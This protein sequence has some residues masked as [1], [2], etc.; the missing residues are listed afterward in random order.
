MKF[1]V[2]LA[3]IALCVW[4]AFDPLRDILENPVR[5]DYYSHILL[6]PVVSL[7]F[8]LRPGMRF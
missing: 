8:L 6:I 5:G 1:A 4:I 3:F 2:M 7:Y